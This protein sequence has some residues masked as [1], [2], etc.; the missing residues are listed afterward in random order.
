MSDEVDVP[1]FLQMK[2]NPEF[3]VPLPAKQMMDQ[4]KEMY[5]TA[6]D[7]LAKAK[8][9]HDESHAEFQR[10]YHLLEVI[11]NFNAAEGYR[12][13]K[14]FQQVL[15]ARRQSKWD[16]AAWQKVVSFM[17]WSQAKMLDV[18]RQVDWSNTSHEEYVKG[19]KQTDNGEA[20]LD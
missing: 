15:I 10:M 19:G 14:R 12:M 16:V 3:T 1:A 11:P 8:R 9:L 6:R 7:E 18:S 17:D 2:A 5:Q 13:A 20:E 4:L